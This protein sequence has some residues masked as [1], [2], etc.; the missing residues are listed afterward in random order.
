MSMMPLILV[1][2]DVYSKSVFKVA[3]SAGYDAA[4]YSID[5]L[6]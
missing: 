4:F 3:E 1:S 5:F 6:R 2:G